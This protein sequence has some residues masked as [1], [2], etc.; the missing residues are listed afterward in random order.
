MTAKPP[1]RFAPEEKRSTQEIK[2][3]MKLYFYSEIKAVNHCKSSAEF[4]GYLDMASRRRRRGVIQARV[5]GIKFL[6]IRRT[7]FLIPNNFTSGI[8]KIPFS[9]LNINLIRC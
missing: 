5:S 9:F 7:F 6:D 3:Q 4:G 1:L 2:F 8:M